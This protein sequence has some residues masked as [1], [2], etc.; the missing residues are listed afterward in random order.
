[1]NWLGRAVE[2][3]QE[4]LCVTALATV[5]GSDPEEGEPSRDAV[6]TA[7]RDFRREQY[8]DTHAAWTVRTMYSDRMLAWVTSKALQAA[9]EQGVFDAASEAR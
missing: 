6:M 7:V 9:R 2:A 5:L 4:L 8:G 1:M 3:A